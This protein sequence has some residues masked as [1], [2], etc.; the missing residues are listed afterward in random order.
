MKILPLLFA[1]GVSI[2]AFAQTNITEYVC[3]PCGASCDEETHSSPG[4]CQHCGMK[5]VDKSTVKF[6][7]LSL[8][9]TCERITKNPNIVLLD[10]RSAGEFSGSNKE[11][12]SYGH[13]KKAI[14][15]NVN[16]LENRLA[17][18]KAYKNAEIIVYCSHSHRSPRATYV[19]S[20]NGFTH[21]KNMAGG[22]STIET[23]PAKDCLSDYY[24]GH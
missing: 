8:A 10:V 11:I 22:V 5:L 19:L 16:E 7:N 6:Q 2:L 21:V 1:F 15:I 3:L 18:L 13:F 9:A 17:E 4:S 20:M 24:V 23:D 14:N 12:Q